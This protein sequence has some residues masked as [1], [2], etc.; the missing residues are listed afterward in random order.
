VFLG[1]PGEPGF[2]DLAEF[3]EKLGFP[4]EP[5]FQ[6]LAEFRE[7]LVFLDEL[8]CRDGLGF[9]GFRGSPDLVEFLVAQGFQV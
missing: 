7:K 6:D 1:F 5:V 2:Q 9:Q 8:G 3:R 4:G